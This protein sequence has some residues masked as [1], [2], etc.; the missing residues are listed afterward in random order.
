MYYVEKKL[1]N[2][3]NITI[4]VFL[5][6]AFNC[7][8]ICRKYFSFAI[9]VTQLRSH[10][11]GIEKLL[12]LILSLTHKR[13]D[14][15]TYFKLGG[16]FF[17]LLLFMNKFNISHMPNSIFQLINSLFKIIMNISKLQHHESHGLTIRH[18]SFSFISKIFLITLVRPS[19]IQFSVFFNT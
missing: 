7:I 6:V 3:N 2:N 10:S 1:Q 9:Q 18:S 11:P 16:C 15:I 19:F 5:K 13:R 14:R 17:E 12:N 4:Q 8:T